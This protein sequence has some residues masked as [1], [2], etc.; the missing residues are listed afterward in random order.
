[1]TI[2]GRGN[3]RLLSIANAEQLRSI[4]KYMLDESGVSVAIRYPRSLA[5]PL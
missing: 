3:R 1:M 4:L 5:L 2:P